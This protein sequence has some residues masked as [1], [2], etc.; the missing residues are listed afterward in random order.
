MESDDK[1]FSYRNRS[2]LRTIIKEKEKVD[3]SFAMFFYSATENILYFGLVH[4]AW[5]FKGCSQK[6][7][8]EYRILTAALLL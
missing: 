6:Q 3:V 4:L 2:S 7:N 1:L 5:L 8:R